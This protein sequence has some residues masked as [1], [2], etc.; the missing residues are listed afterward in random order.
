MGLVFKKGDRGGPPPRGEH[1]KKASHTTGPKQGIAGVP[2]PQAEKKSGVVREEELEA[3]PCGVSE[4]GI[5]GSQDTKT[6]RDSTVMELEQ[7]V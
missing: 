7:S 6:N 4:E 5:A 2:R 1:D 3:T